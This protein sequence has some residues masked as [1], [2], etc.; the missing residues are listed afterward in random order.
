MCVSV[1]IKINKK[2]KTMATDRGTR[3]NFLKIFLFSGLNN[4]LVVVISNFLQEI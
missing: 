4:S 2:L 1:G 3:L